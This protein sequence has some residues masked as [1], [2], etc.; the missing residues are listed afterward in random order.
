MLNIIYNK[1]YNKIIYYLVLVTPV[2]VPSPCPTTVVITS[3]T[4]TISK[5]KIVIIF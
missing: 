3:E 2:N 5:Y 1:N 4:S